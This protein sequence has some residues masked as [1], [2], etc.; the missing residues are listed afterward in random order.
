[1]KRFL[2]LLLALAML[3]SGLPV[4]AL[5]LSGD[6]AAPTEAAVVE[7]TASAEET[8]VPEASSEPETT[9]T[10]ASEPSI[11]ETTVETEP[12]VIETTAETESAVPETTAATEPSVPGT[13]EATEMPMFFAFRGSA[14]NFSGKVI[15]IMG[16]SISTFAGYIPTAD[17]FNLEHLARYPQDDLLTDVNETWWMQVITELDAKLGINDSWRGATLSGGAPVT[18]GTTGENAAMS[19]L[20]RIQNLGANGTP[21][22]ILLYGGTNDLAHVSKVGSFNAATAPTSVDLTTAKWDNLADGF[23]HTLLRMRHYYPNAQ[24]VAL[25]PAVTTSY[26]SNEKLA[27]ANAVMAQICQ[28][29][30]IPYTDLRD[31]GITTAEL[32]D[33]IH[34]NAAGMDYIT[35]AVLD[36]LLSQC[37]VEAGENKVY[38]VSHKL[39]S[40]SASKHYYKGVSAGTKFEETVSGEDLTVTVTMGGAD[41][42]SEVYADGKIT[43]SNVTGDIVVTAKAVFSLG[44]RLLQLPEKLCAGLNLWTALEHD[45]EYYTASGWGVHSSGKVYSVTIPVKAGDRLWATSF[46][47][48]ALN[49]SPSSNGIRVTYFSEDGMLDSLTSTETYNELTQN[50]Y[51]TVPEQA[52]AVN[53]PMWTNEDSNELYLLNAEHSYENGKCAICG[54]KAPE[55]SGKTISILGASIS[56]YEGTSNGAAADTTNSTIRNNV[57]YYPNNTIPEV[58]LNDTW[59]MQVAEDLDLR[60]LVNNAWSGSAILLERS[61]TVGAYVDRC[62][63]LHDNTGDNAGEEPDIICIQ[64]G[65]NDFSYGKDTLGDANIDYAALITADGYGTPSTTMEATAIMLDKITKRYPN[66]EVYM[67]NHFKRI[68]QSASDTTLMEGLNASIQT[69]CDRFGVSVVDLYTTLT[70][71]AHI[72][73]GKLHPNR[74]G[75]DVISEAV[76]SAIIGNTD[77]EVTTHTAKLALDGVT[78]DY[79]TD[80]I[81][82][83]GTGFSVKL[84]APAG[85]TLSVTVT[86]GGKDITADCY[87]AQDGKVSI[88]AVTG[89]VVITAKRVHTPKDYRWEFNGTDLA[90]E[91]TLTK[92]AGTTTDGIFSTTRYDIATPVVLSHEEP[93]VVEWKSEGTFQNASGS[94]ARVFTTDKVN[95]NYNARYIFKSNTRGIIAMGEKTTTGSHNY[96]IALADHGIDWTAL[97]TYRLENRIAQDGSNMI[98]LLVDGKEIGPMTHYFVGTTDKKTTS[99]W[100]SG[101]DFVFPYMGTDSH[102]FNDC[103][104][105][106][107]AVWEGGH[108]HVYESVVTKPTCT[109]KGYTT[110]T[111]TVCS[112]SY[113]DSYVDATGHSFGAWTETKVPTCEADG[114]ERRNCESC[115][116]FETRAVTCGHNPEY[117][118]DVDGDGVLELLAIGNSFSVD[119]LE[120]FWQIANDLGIQKVVVGNFYIS[121]CTLKTHAANAANDAAAYTYYYND[122]GVWSKTENYKLSTALTERSWDYISMQQSSRYSGMESTYNEDLTN[123]ISYVKG[124]ISKKENENRNPCAKLVWHMTWAYQQDSTNTGFA[125]Y[126]ND[127]M[128]MYNAI[129][130]AVQNKIVTN[131][132]FDLIV[133]NGTAVQ[134]SRTSLLGDT[135]TRDGYHMSR[136]YGRY[137]TGLLFVKTVT[138][139]SVDG[140]TYAPSGVDTQ[141]TAIAIESVNNAYANPFEVTKSAYTGEVPEEGY[142]LLQ[143]EFYKGA[144][145]DSTSATGYNKLF[146]DKSISQNYFATIRFTKETLPVGSIIILADGWRYRPDGWI[147]DTVQTGPREPMTTES[148]VVVTEEWWDDYT[149]RA[150]NICRVDGGSVM[151]LTENEMRDI[152]RIYVPEESHVHTYT[153]VVTAPTCTEKG[154]TTHTC[155]CGDSYV[156]SYVDAFGHSFGDWKVTTDA[157]CTEKGEERHDCT[158]CDHFE[159][160]EIAAKGHTEVI[161]KAVEPTCTETGLTEGKH[162]SAC[163]TVLVKQNEIPAK[164]HSFGAWS[165]T[166]AATCTEK[167]EERRDCANCDHFETREIAA[168]G[169][170]EVIDKAVEATCTESGLTE[171]KHCSVCGTVLVKQKE[172]PAKGHSFGAWSETKAATCTEKG[173][174]RR[175]CDNCDHFETREIAAKGHTE[176]ID[177]AVEPTCTETG[178]TEG[179]HCS[180]CGAVLVKQKEIPAKGHSFGAWKT[181]TEATCTEKGEERRDCANCDHFETR[182]I[183]AK[184]HTEVIDKAVEP[185]CTETGLTEGKHCSVCGTVLVKQKE[186]PAKGHSF[187]AWSETKAAT[188]TEKGEERR[189]CANC[190]HYETREIAAKGHS[191]GEWVEISAPTCTEAGEQQRK[192]VCGH[193]ETRSVEALGHEEVIDEGLKPTCTEG[194]ISDGKHCGRCGEIL[195]EQVELPAAGHSYSTEP[196]FL[197]T[198]NNTVCK[199]YFH[200]S[201]CD[202]IKVKVCTVTTDTENNKILHTATVE[203]EGKTFTDV[204]EE[205]LEDIL[206]GD[207]NGDGKVNTKDA[208]RILRYYAELI[209]DSEIDL[210]AADVNSDGNVNTKDATRVLRYYAEL[211]DS[212]RHEK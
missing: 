116:A 207:A 61:G 123:L 88:A 144:F 74:L 121:G 44:D 148:Y 94:G 85:D 48:S 62:V 164:G 21:D 198:E 35:A 149:I 152:F 82:V 185:T 106:Y 16:D 201:H 47:S 161:D 14:E 81:V 208:T 145:W 77:Y 28:H 170:T 167:G 42:T 66:A 120:Y 56:T 67:F 124:L 142:I 32:P 24:I 113:V 4:E 173:E 12:A 54:E 117:S 115:D 184:G 96:G 158:N 7:T 34:P 202:A 8:T 118:W 57:K 2:S 190:D 143:S 160:R 172:I 159:T 105:E 84:T 135:T 17:G 53:I 43:I 27:E 155:A 169:H 112:D 41:I 163:K 136:D 194:G 186:I 11:P 40:A 38:S 129:V 151:D 75:M 91:N 90:G 10:E 55:L 79:G 69:V 141:E 130:S 204:K 119:A 76:K 97:H 13:T 37:E 68:G 64:M 93:W 104:I 73:D 134:N 125:N 180:V 52:N 36:V 102:G 157:T 200:C 65:F 179:K 171:G 110:H 150:F 107:I 138:G 51:L 197:W 22:I 132:A 98:Y 46:Q 147:T 20:V 137:L 178:L 193:S 205:E 100:L 189:D 212:L 83:D 19:N 49:G 99:Q 31:C 154:Y 60:L 18:T 175:D 114:E 153:S 109:E 177:K 33:G 210:V 211:I 50:G 156:D 126:N 209:S 29:Y 45:P 15:S 101:K 191:Y 165:K 128:T 89:D 26:Y 95:A 192:C 30:G 3:V 199:A 166:K 9:G 203:F 111:C 71:P 86:M 139:L 133:P 63:Q 39:T 195:K 168:K 58:G 131:T 140:I 122:N 1:M 206:W 183:A 196:K 59:W 182:E 5:A 174:E 80:K 78:A 108:E 127:Q 70:D 72:G 176:V 103:A 188:C 87:Y 23:V 6:A 187:G 162:C 181:T 25:L 92:T 146:F